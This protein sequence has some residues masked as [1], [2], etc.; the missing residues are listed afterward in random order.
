MVARGMRDSP[1]MTPLE[2]QVRAV[3]DG[4]GISVHEAARRSKLPVRSLFRVLEGK[5]APSDETLSALA[6]GLGARLTRPART[7]NPDGSVQ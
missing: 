2:Q 3:I 1:P 4:A 6:Q 5:H 7:F